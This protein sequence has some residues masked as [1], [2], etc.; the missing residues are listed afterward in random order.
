MSRIA[1]SP[2]ILAV[3]VSAQVRTLVDYEAFFS[4]FVCKIC[5]CRS[6]KT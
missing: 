3:D 2:D 6:K 5:E 4:R 1:D